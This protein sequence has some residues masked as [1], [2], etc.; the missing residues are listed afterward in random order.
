MEKISV[1]NIEN[2]LV[3][4][5][6]YNSTPGVGTTRILFT[7]VELAGREYIKNI[8]KEIGLK[9]TEDSI[10]N[11]F[12]TL[13]GEEKDLSPVWTG[14][15]IDTVN[16]AGMFDGMTGVIGGM[17]ALRSIIKSGIKPKRSIQVIVFTSEEPTRFKI[18]CLGSRAM[19]GELTLEDTKKY[20]D[21]SG[22]TLYNLLGKLGY[23]Y[24]SFYKI[25]RNK[26]DVYAMVEMHVEQSEKLEQLN[27]PIGVVTSISA[28]T[29]I[30]VEI[31]GTQEHAG[32]TEMSLRKDSLAGAAEIILEVEK[33]AKAT[34]RRETVATVGKLTVFPN[35]SNVIS[36]D[37]K[38]SIDMRENNFEVKEKIFNRLFELFKELEVKRSLK[39]NTIVEYHDK[40]STSDPHIMEIIE[41]VCKEKN[42]EYHK[43]N[44][45]AFHDSMFV[46]SFAPNAMIFVPSKDG[47]SHS[48]EEFTKFSEIAVGT[49][50]LRDTL[51]KLAME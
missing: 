26:G 8:M 33:L 18:G 17:E 4:L 41:D 28:G 47:V 31:L 12:G 49:E 34:G 15:H 27:I 40:P 22:M 6:E 35:S 36:G 48:K 42:I 3:G 37:V 45:G 5:N 51:L 30:D 14:S 10:G 2:W 38:L 29:V 9:V 13:E 43:M 20:T 7:D 19:A 44:S 46:A 50:V 25:K 39:I 32:A 11:I 24:E 21:D 1:E 16:N 23:D